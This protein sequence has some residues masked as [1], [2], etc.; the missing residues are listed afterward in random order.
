ME[1]TSL[2]ILKRTIG[3][4]LGEILVE[5][6]IIN[7]EQL[8]KALA[9]H[10]DSRK[11]IPSGA[12]LIKLGFASEQDVVHAVNIQYPFPYLPVDNYEIDP[13]VIR[14]I[15]NRIAR[16]H[17]LIPIDRMANII[18][19]AMS[20]P[21]NTEALKDVKAI[22][23]CEVRTFIATPSEIMR[24]IDKY[25][26]DNNDDGF[27]I[28]RE[29]PRIKVNT[30]TRATVILKDHLTTG[31][32]LRDI[33]ARGI[34]GLTSYA[35]KIEEQIEIILNHPFFEIPVKKRA[36]VVWCKPNVKNKRSWKAKNI[37]IC[38]RRSSDTVS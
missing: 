17:L 12:A 2:S 13:E 21:L 23:K 14:I 9:L 22:S 3:K 34:C 5:L 6:G 16:K 11:Y 27:P 26:S 15:P 24:A 29:C 18:T 10:K 31:M 19:I 30:R 8:N 1:E 28:K 36:R 4:R 37:Q 33:S 32:K 38:T 7:E 25:Y 20:N 35:F